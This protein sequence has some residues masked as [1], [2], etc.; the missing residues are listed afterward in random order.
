[1]TTK[2]KAK[3]F[4]IKRTG[5]LADGQ[6]SAPPAAPAAAPNPA[7]VAPAQAQAQP[8]TQRPAAPQQQAQPQPQR[9]QPQQT[10]QPQTQA[11]GRIQP[12]KKEVPVGA[13]QAQAQAQVQNQAQARAGLVSSAAEAASEQ[14]I[15]AIKREGLTGRQLRMARRAA[16]KYGLAPTSDYD[17]VRQLRT[18][19]ID[20]F[21]RTNMLELVVPS[22]GDTAGKGGSSATQPLL[23]QDPTLEPINLP[24]TMAAGA[25]MPAHPTGPSPAE[26]RADEITQIQRDIAKRRRRKLALLFTRLA[27]FVFLPTLIVG[28]YYYFIA[29][30]MYAT[31]SEFLILKAESSGGGAMGGLLSGTQFAT[32]QDAIAVQSYL[33]SKDAML[34][35]DEDEGFMS[36]FMN[37]EIDVIQ[38][39][40]ENPSNEDAYKIFKKAIEIGYD[41]TEGVIKM[42][43]V[44]ADPQVSAKFSKALISYAEA[45]VDNLS[46]RKRENQVADADRSFQNAD[47]ERRIAQ[48]RLVRLQQEGSIL[49]PEGKI[50]SLRSQINNIEVQLQGKE[51]ELAALLDNN[52]PNRAKVEGAEG[53][54]R[55]YQ[56]LLDRLNSQMT[57]AS[58]GEN[59]LA[60]LAS[61]IQLAQADVATRDMM[62][63][64]ALEQLE[65]TRREAASQARYLTT[66]VEPV[67]SQDP[68]YPRKFE[69]TILA[70]LV[71]AGLYLM[72]SLTASILREQVSS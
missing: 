37:P 12:V 31:K 65:Q 17:A 63:A 5:S 4:R 64:S 33:A 22:E 69:N 46:L 32:N 13:T 6:Q 8:Q 52:R 29:T 68:T 30:P 43:V 18:R 3:K 36:H 62:L 48:E 14:D 53:D 71:F 26:R 45:R 7:R 49:D 55:R 39:L 27:F 58:Q 56:A 35:L 38:R 34:R 15:D 57:D 19:G 47:A 10:Q 42:E 23:P 11:M 61:Q 40:E 2:P 59:S 25:N 70:F 41:P 9:A 16:Q 50:A 20:P 66:S 54:V 44:A 60:E 28:W 24:Q 21:Q 67:P 51:L 1:M 72:I